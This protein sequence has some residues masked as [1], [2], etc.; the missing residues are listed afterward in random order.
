VSGFVRFAHLSE[1]RSRRCPRVRRFGPLSL[2]RD[3]WLAHGRS[4]VI[5]ACRRGALVRCVSVVNVLFRTVDYSIHI[6]K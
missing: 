4:P 3:L 1:C 2:R 6:I 5:T